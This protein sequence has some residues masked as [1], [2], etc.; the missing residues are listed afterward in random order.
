MNMMDPKGHTTVRL[1]R[2]HCTFVNGIFVKDMS[3]VG[4]NMKDTI[5]IDNSP[6]A[7]MLQPECG[8]PIVSWYDDPH[9]RALY[10]YI[11]LLIE[12]AKVNDMREAVTGFVRNNT[13]TVSHAMSIVAHIREKDN[14]EAH[15]RMELERA[16]KQYLL[17]QMQQNQ[18]NQAAAAGKAE[19]EAEL[20][21]V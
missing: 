21:H 6:T 10:D 14:V 7:Y 4:R 16:R 15:K 2:E 17:Q 20:Q 1:F 5:I 9:D 18:A 3:Q 13:F 12:M 11:P 19:S 8:L